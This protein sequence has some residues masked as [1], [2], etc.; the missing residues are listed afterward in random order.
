VYKHAL[1]GRMN[2]NLS[3][4]L[5]SMLYLFSFQNKFI[6]SSFLDRVHEVKPPGYEP[7]DQVCLKLRND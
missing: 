3:I 6:Y 7:S 1:N 4:V 2:I 5:N